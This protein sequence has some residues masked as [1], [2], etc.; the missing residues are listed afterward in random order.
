MLYLRLAG[1]L[2]N[3]VFQLAAAMALRELRQERVLF[4][5]EGL[6][7]YQ[8]ARALELTRFFDLPSW[9]ETCNS[10]GRHGRIAEAV[11]RT[12]MGRLAPLLGINDRAFGARVVSDRRGPR[13]ALLDGYFQ[14]DWPWATFDETRRALMKMMVAPLRASDT[15]VKYD[16]VMHVRG[17]DFLQSRNLNVVSPQYY[18]RA[19]RALRDTLDIRRIYVVTDD[20]TYARSLLGPLKKSVSNLELVIPDVA[21]DMLSDFATIR[22]AQ[23]RIIGNSTFSWW[24]AALDPREAPTVAP[25]QWSRGLDRNLVLPW[26]RLLGI[27]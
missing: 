20:P 8:A 19:V 9:F 17:G 5:V 13:V 25:T 26:E 11:L 1:G 27:D 16:C 18:E 12:R 14:R 21:T 4:G 22:H 23:C 7:R 3:Q 2:G 24:A 15:S 6:G 10:C